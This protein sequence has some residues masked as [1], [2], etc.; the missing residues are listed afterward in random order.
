MVSRPFRTRHLGGE[1]IVRLILDGTVV[2]VRLDRKATSVSLLVVLGVRRDGQKVLLT[3]RSMGGESEAAWR[4]VLEDHQI[5][6]GVTNHH[7]APGPG[8]CAVS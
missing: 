3:I 7:V 1:D 6:L 4:A 2:R 8:G 5:V